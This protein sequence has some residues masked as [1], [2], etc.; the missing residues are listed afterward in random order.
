VAKKVTALGNVALV[1][2]SQHQLIPECRNTL[3]ADAGRRGLTGEAKAR[4]AGDDQMEGVCRVTTV[5]RGV[6]ER[7]DDV[8]KLE[9]RSWPAMGNQ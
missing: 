5:L 1:A 7:P 9:H 8:E 2:E 3:H 4:Q 6:A